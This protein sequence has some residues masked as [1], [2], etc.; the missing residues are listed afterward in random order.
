M[1]IV[2]ATF[3]PS[4][5]KDGNEYFEWVEIYEGSI[6]GSVE[7]DVEWDDAWTGNEKYL[8]LVDG[9]VQFDT[10]VLYSEDRA[11]NYP[12]IT[13]QLDK[14]YHDIQNGTLTAEGDFASA[15]KAIKDAYPKT[16]S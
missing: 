6:P 16:S 9:S 10:T 13:E 5:D 14:L 7:I 3:A 2:T 1:A 15:I 12:D 11:Q 4:F 8:R